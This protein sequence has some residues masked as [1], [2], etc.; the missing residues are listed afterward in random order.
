MTDGNID[1]E[2]H[3][4]RLSHSE[5]LA[6]TGDR[7]L[8]D[9]KGKYEDIKGTYEDLMG[10]YGSMK[11]KYEYLTGRYDDADFADEYNDF[12]YHYNELADYYKEFTDEYEALKVSTVICNLSGKLEAVEMEDFSFAESETKSA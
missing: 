3:G 1:H 11:G 10:E 6:R 5:Y 2:L 12:T 7:V 4:E 8:E 9:I